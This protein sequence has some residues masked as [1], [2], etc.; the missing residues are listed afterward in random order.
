MG[1][2]D[3][4]LATYGVELGA[5]AGQVEDRRYMLEISSELGF[6]VDLSF[7]DFGSTNRRKLKQRR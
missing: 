6:D 1:P 7:S 2:L 4:E 5:Y 3:I